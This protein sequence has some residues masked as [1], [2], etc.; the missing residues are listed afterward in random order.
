MT[1]Q[2]GACSIKGDI[3]RAGEAATASRTPFKAST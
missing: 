1:M 2:P 3:D